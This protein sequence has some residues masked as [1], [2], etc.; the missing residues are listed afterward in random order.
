MSDQKLITWLGGQIK[1][2]MSRSI[3]TS[4]VA[5]IINVSEYESLQTVDVQP[6][7]QYQEEDGD[8]LQM[9]VIYRCPVQLEGSS[10]GIFSFP[11]KVGDLVELNFSKYSLQELLSGVSNDP[12]LP[13][14]RRLFGQSEAFVHASINKAGDSIKPSATNAQ[15]KFKNSAIVMSPS[16]SM[17]LTNGSALVV[18]NSDGSATVNGATITPDG[19][20]ITANGTD[21][22]AFYQEYLAHLHTSGT[23][24][25]PTSPPIP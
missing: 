4:C 8:I 6:L 5:K 17:T 25:S 22:D 10:E 12:Y 18:L 15:W 13:T 2:E 20:V 16:G 23:P 1:G 7:A 21:L 9:P 3:E 11:L 24:G 19:N 14:D